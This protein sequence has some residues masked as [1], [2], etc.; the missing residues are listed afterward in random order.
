MPNRSADMVENQIDFLPCFD[1]VTSSPQLFFKLFKQK[2][3]FPQT[4]SVVIHFFCIHKCFKE[5]T[6]CCTQDSPSSPEQTVG[7]EMFWM[8]ED[9]ELRGLAD[10]QLLKLSLTSQPCAAG[11]QRF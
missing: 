9:P 2:E 8:V 5:A 3:V 6:C 10:F 4:R 7:G 1:L 11:C